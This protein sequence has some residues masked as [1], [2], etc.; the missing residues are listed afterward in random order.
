[1]I[2]EAMLGRGNRAFE[3][4]KAILPSAKNTSADLHRT[5]PY[6]YCQVIAGKRHPSFGEGKNSWLTGSAC[7]NFVAASQWILGIR[8][9]YG[10]LVVDPCIPAHW[11]G[12]EA[13]RKFRG[14]TYYIVVRNPDGVE[15]G[16]KSI[17]LDGK[18]IK[19]GV[20]PPVLDG[21]EHQVEVVMGETKN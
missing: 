2:A 18:K 13:K 21:G 11:K 19:G 4:Y 10:G 17:T 12:F 20:V 6:V 8:A 15:K 1:M 16:V 3:Y 14:D 9:D 7:W 5:E